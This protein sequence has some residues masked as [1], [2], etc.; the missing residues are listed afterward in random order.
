VG[1]TNQTSLF[2]EALLP[3]SKS[4][5]EYFILLSPDTKVKAEIMKFRQMMHTEF[6]ITDVNLH[7][8]PHISFIAV[9]FNHAI[10]DI[11][12]YKLNTL[13]RTENAFTVFLRG[14]DVFPG[15][16]RT[17]TFY[18]VIHNEA[19]VARL[20]EKTLRAFNKKG[21]GLKPHLTVARNI[22]KGKYEKTFALL[23]SAGYESSFYCN[24]ITVLKR[25]IENNKA[26]NY[27]MLFEVP[28][29]K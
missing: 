9:C 1:I 2:E 6:D 11:I 29:K 20:Q 10:D 22:P 26:G 14:F 19:E 3:E 7:S 18:A 25:K 15:K 23:R 8:V 27:E 12:R 16:G 24:K 13:F 17:E 28:L 4:E 21:T 5:V